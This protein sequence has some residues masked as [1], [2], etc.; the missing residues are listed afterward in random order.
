M[1][2]TLQR[3]LTLSFLLL[4]EPARIAE[5]LP[6]ADRRLGDAIEAHITFLADDLLE[7]RGTGTPG[8]DIAARYVA[9]QFRQLGLKPGG[10]SNSW[11]QS[12]PL[13]E[14][15]LAAEGVRCELRGDGDTN[16][17]DYNLDYV[18]R[19]HFTETNSSVTAPL[20][21]VGFGVKAPKFAYDDF[22][23]T[24][25]RGKIAV[26][27]VKAPPRFPS[28]ALAHYAHVREKTKTLMAAGAV[29]VIG[30]PTPKD[31]E[32]TPWPQMVTRARFA[33]MRW[34]QADGTPA[35]VFPQSK[36]ALSVSPRGAGKLFAHSPKPLAAAL[37]AAAKSEPQS[38]PLNLVASITTRS[39]HQRVRSPNVLAVLPGNDPVLSKESVIF[40]AHLDHQGRGPAVNG[41][42]IYNGAYD[43]AI[44]I[45]MMIEAAR[46]LAAEGK[47]LRRTVVFAAVTAEE[48][49]LVGSE[50]LAGHLPAQA[51]MPIANLN[52]DMVLVSAPTRSYTVLGTEHSTLRGPVEAAARE[53]GL[54]LRPDPKPE[55]VTFVRSDQYSFIRLGVPAIFPKVV[56]DTKAAP[57]TAGLSV[58][59]FIKDHYHRPSDDLS[60][61]R[62]A[63]SAVRFVRFMA[64]VA[65]R[66]ANA[67]EAPRWNPGDFFGE[68]F[69]Q[70]PKR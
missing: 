38:F 19:P 24:D 66:V 35:D 63:A 40:T 15:R 18:A 47:G 54:E 11:F 26:V 21:F 67:K 10:E 12:V 32:E 16:V 60:L 62:D 6:P 64:D 59:T 1:K 39:E 65:R 34:L 68:Q 53:F 43:N 27:L 52:L 36:A 69:G 28:T 31:L 37:A 9:S 41:D 13:L 61:P 20:V 49:G 55:S 17:L 70:Q 44:G 57:G 30:V 29:G 48:K 42:T 56:D 14:S 33:A 3:L 22:G 45:A 8:H 4:I 7:G 51:G 58:A 46:L 25:V 23:A 5:T 50:F 2:S